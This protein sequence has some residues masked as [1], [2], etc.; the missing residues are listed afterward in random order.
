MCLTSPSQQA[1]P[2]S[3]CWTVTAAPLVVSSTGLTQ[4]LSNNAPTY[5]PWQERAAATLANCLSKDAGGKVFLQRMGVVKPLKAML[6][7]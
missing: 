6:F 3:P 2:K 1:H 7:R 5:V 4:M